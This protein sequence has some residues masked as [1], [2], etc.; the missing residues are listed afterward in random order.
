MPLT[1]NL[2]LEKSDGSEIDFIP[3][4]IT[5]FEGVFINLQVMKSEILKINSKLTKPETLFSLRQ[6]KFY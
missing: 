5:A 2:L 1:V 4:G 3:R 6:I